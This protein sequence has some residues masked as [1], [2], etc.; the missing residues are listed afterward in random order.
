MP[1]SIRP[2]SINFGAAPLRHRSPWPRERS[3]MGQ[4]IYGYGPAEHEYSVTVPELTAG[5][6]VIVIYLSAHGGGTV[7]EA[8]ANNGWDYLV[9]SDGRPVIEGSDLRSAPA[10]AS[11]HAEM[12]RALASFLA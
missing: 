11:G 6:P 5:D 10:R 7:G 2:L 8:Y 9:T 1:G 12:A 4:Q 3:A